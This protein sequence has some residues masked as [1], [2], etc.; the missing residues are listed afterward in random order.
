MLRQYQLEDLNFLKDKN[1]CALFNEPR[2]G[3]TPVAISWLKVRNCSNCLVICPASAIPGWQYELYNWYNNLQVYTC[4]G[5]KKNKDKT[6]KDFI[7]DIRPKVL[8]ISYDSLK[9]TKTREGY[10][11][12]LLGAKIEGVAVDEAHRIRGRTTSTAKAVFRLTRRIPNVIAM[13]GTPAF[14]KPEDLYSILHMLFPTK[15]KSYWDWVAEWC[16]TKEGYNAQANITYTL[17]TGIKKAKQQELINILKSFSTIRKRKDVMPWLPDTTKLQV[18][19]PLTTKQKFCLTELDKW[20]K[21]EDVVT[22]GILDRLIRYRQ[23]CDSPEL[24]DLDKKSPKTDWIKQY[25]KDY[26]EESVLVFSN[27]TEYLKLL[28][29]DIPEAEMIIGST[30]IKNRGEI[31]KRFQDGKTKILLINI[32]AGREALTLDRADVTIFTD[33][34]PPVGAIEQAEAR[35]LATTEQQAHRG[36]KIVELMMEDSYDEEIYKMLGRRAREVDII[37]NYNKYIERS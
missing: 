7:I 35:F 16:D 12:L 30:S 18:K 2:T 29:R 10:V 5:T 22:Q 17:V 14:G 25:L 21:V 13:T 8:I 1:R 23:I 33:K 34:Y 27:F 37:N 15:Y 4:T 24:L 36:H 19:L 9:A 31:C 6:I 11:D 3:K 26:P 20:F 28:Q 32:Q